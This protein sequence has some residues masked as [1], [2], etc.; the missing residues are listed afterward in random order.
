MDELLALPELRSILLLSLKAT[1]S[2]IDAEAAQ[3]GSRPAAST[4]E[5]ELPRTPAFRK[6]VEE[7]LF[8]RRFI[9]TYYI[10]VLCVLVVFAA[11][12]WC[13]RWKSWSGRAKTGR[14]VDVDE[15]GSSTASSSSSTLQGSR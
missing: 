14:W 10:A 9:L 3:Y 11:A 2:D 1:S 15:Q 4:A 12:H 8:S 6:L 7:I 13:T 5:P